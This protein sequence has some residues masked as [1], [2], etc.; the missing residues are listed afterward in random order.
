MTMAPRN[1][2][3]VQSV[4][5]KCS[6][7]P[8]FCVVIAFTFQL[9]SHT[10]GFAL[11]VLS[12]KP[13]SQASSL[14]SPSCV[15]FFWRVGF[16]IPTARFDFLRM[17]ASRALALSAINSHFFYARKSRYECALGERLEPT[18]STFVGARTTYQATGDAGSWNRLP[19]HY[20]PA[21]RR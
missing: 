1:N 11:S 17:L 10:G 6:C 13:W 4:G 16:S 3:S 5:T 20:K 15:R 8:F 9:S 12:D 14:P 7:P 18:K 21:P 2:K 19:C